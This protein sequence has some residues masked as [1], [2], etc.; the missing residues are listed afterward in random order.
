MNIL[1]YFQ[2]HGRMRTSFYGFAAMGM[3]CIAGTSLPSAAH[4]QSTTA[5]IF[6]RAPAG[7]TIVAQSSSG[8]H[9][10]T[11]A[12]A[13]GRYKFSSLPQSTYTVI[14]QKDGNTVDTQSNIALIV[15]RGA[16]VDFACPNDQC[17]ASASR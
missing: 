15:G 9:R 16:E 13:E 11:K 2:T 6:G 14:L 7:E 12:N 10:G 17:A 8:L 1:R 5:S 3:L 4:A